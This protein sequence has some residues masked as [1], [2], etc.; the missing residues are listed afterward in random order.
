MSNDQPL[1]VCSLNSFRNIGA[2]AFEAALRVVQAG[3]D[4]QLD[5]EVDAAPAQ[6]A[7]G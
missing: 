5:D 7:V 2:E 6:V 3:Q 4:E 1:S